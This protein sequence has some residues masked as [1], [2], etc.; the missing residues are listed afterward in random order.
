MYVCGKKC[1]FGLEFDYFLVWFPLAFQ[2]HTVSWI[3]ISKVPMVSVNVCPVM[4]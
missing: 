3:C 2:K 4:D 1:V